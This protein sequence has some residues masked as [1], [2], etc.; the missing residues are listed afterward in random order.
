MLS[1]FAPAKVNLFLSIIKKREDGYHDIGTMFHTISCG[2]VLFG[3]LSTDGKISISYNNP[4]EYPP[5]KDLIYKAAVKL[6]EAFGVSSGVNFYLEKNLPL[7]A[8]LGGGSSDAAA[9]LRLLNKLWGLNASSLELEKIGSGLGAD[10]AFF[11]KGGA[12]LAEGIGDILTPRNSISSESCAIVVAT[13]K[14]VVPTAEA[15]R[16]VIPAGNM[17]WQN[18]MK[19]MDPLNDLYN[20]FEDTVLK[21]YPLINL[22]R[23]KLNAC[24][25][26]SLLAGSGASVFSL[27]TSLENAARAYDLVK[28]ECRFLQICHF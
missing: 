11:V 21:K 25:G 27:F 3:E 17:R 28:D 16:D 7:G 23:Q 18:F 15:Y 6:K 14:C 19:N 2:D 5:E 20:Q 4:Q 12:A 13:P 24:G 26:K 9:A 1:E 10:I 8:G 22:L